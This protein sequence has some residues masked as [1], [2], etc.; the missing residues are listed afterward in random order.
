[1]PGNSLV[2]IFLI[3]LILSGPF[4]KILLPEVLIFAPTFFN[5]SISVLIIF[6]SKSKTIN[7]STKIIEKNSL[8]KS[9]K[10]FLKNKGPRL[11]ILSTEEIAEFF[12]EKDTFS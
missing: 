2:F 7:Q 3:G 9:G 1:M 10:G 12:T 11:G 5:S 8:S 4:I 6:G